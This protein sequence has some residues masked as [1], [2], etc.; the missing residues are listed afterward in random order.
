MLNHQKGRIYPQQLEG[1]EYYFGQ[2]E[3]AAVLPNFLTLSPFEQLQRG[4][5]L[6]PSPSQTVDELQQENIR[7]EY[8]PPTP[9]PAEPQ[10]EVVERENAVRRAIRRIFG[11]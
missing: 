3:Y 7:K 1:L 6:F 4:G 2:D 5:T 10:S 11:R 9:I 8:T